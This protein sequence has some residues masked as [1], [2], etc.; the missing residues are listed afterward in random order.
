MKFNTY[1]LYGRAFVIFSIMCALSFFIFYFNNYL[2][3][4]GELYK[5][6]VHYE[7]LEYVRFAIVEIIDFLLPTL[8]A[9]LIF[10]RLLTERAYRAYPSAL[11]LCSA[12][13]F[14]NILYYYLYHLAYGYDSIESISI[15]I[16]FSVFISALYALYAVALAYAAKL[17]YVRRGGD[18]KALGER[19]FSLMPASPIDYAVLTVVFVQFGIRFVGELVETVIFFIEY[20]DSYRIGELIYILGSFVYILITMLLGA[21]IA[22][23]VYNKIIAKR[24]SVDV[25]GDEKAA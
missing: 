2:L 23:L 18:F 6:S 3:F 8:S 7:T 15:S 16:P 11:I 19:C 24:I 5:Y 10:P 1:R 20:A 14:H 21:L 13:L 22:S 25:G 12:H 17:V 9:L 4:D